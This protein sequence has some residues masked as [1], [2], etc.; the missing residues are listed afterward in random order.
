MSSGSQSA[1]PSRTGRWPLP[2]GLVITSG[3]QTPYVKPK[4]EGP[5]ALPPPRGC[6]QELER[7]GAGKPEASPGPAP[8]G[9]ALWP[10]CQPAG[11]RVECLT[12][13]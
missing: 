13:A 8:L 4:L 3:F 1:N 9:S 12:W 7:S 11:Y 10:T 5:A 2:S 6:Q